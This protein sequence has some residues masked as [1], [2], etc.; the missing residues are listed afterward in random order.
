M[1][2]DNSPIIDFY[3]DLNDIQ[4]DLNGKQQ[5]WQAVMLIPF[6]DEV[7]LQAKTFSESNSEKLHHSENCHE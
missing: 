7:N 1:V 6:I 4:I 3:P 2:K 5:E